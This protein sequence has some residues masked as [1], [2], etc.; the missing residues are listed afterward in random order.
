[1]RVGRYDYL[2]VCS[3]GGSKPAAQSSLRLPT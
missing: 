3:R 1:M 2:R